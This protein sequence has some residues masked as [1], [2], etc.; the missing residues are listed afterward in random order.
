VTDEPRPRASF[1]TN[2][3]EMRATMLAVGAVIVA[4]GVA[5]LIGVVVHGSRSTDDVAVTEIEYHITMPTTLHSGRHTFAVTNLGAE[6]HEFVVF[7][8]DLAAA[9]L[10]RAGSKVND[11]SPLLHLVADSG[12]ALPPGATRA[13]SATLSAGHYV[14]LCNLPSHYGLGMRVDVT[15]TN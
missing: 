14:V 4:L 5:V 13:V 10:P 8:T 12:S 7:R 15:V 2:I 11:A 6:P 3:R 1:R 9:S